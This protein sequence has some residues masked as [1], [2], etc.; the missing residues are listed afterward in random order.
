MTNKFPATDCPNLYRRSS[1]TECARSSPSNPTESKNTVLASSKET[2]CLSSL[3]FAFLESHSNISI[4]YIL[5]SID[6]Q[7]SPQQLRKGIQA[8][9]V[10]AE[11]RRSDRKSGQAP[12]GTVPH[13]DCPLLSRS[14]SPFLPQAHEWESYAAFPGAALVRTRSSISQSST[15]SKDKS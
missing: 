10:Q 4:M 1:C 6:P 14:Q 5:N 9:G 3:L 15:C 11:G 2:P 13:R 12:A 7:A 8:E